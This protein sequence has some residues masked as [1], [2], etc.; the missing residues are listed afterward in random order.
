[1]LKKRLLVSLAAC[2]VKPGLNL[3]WCFGI[4]LI[5]ITRSVL[6]CVAGV[7]VLLVS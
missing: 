4:E 7:D 6:H 2:T 3:T 1:M 5:S